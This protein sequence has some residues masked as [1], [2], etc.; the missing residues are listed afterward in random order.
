MAS[1]PSPPDLQSGE[2]YNVFISHG[3]GE[4]DEAKKLLRVLEEEHHL[5]C[6]LPERD[7]LPGESTVRSI[8]EG[9]QMSQKVILLV[10]MTFLK[11]FYMEIEVAEALRKM[12]SQKKTVLIP[13][14][15][16]VDIADVPSSI[17][18]VNCIEMRKEGWMD[19]LL[20]GV[21]AP[22][23]SAATELVPPG[24]IGDGLA[25][26]YYYGY[27]KLILPGLRQRAEESEFAKGGK[28]MLKK[29]IAVLPETA[30]CP[31][32]FEA[33]DPSIKTI[34]AI[35]FLI[36]MSGNVKRSYKTTVHQVT[37]PRDESKVYLFLG[38]FCTPLRSLYEM[39]AGGIAGLTAEDRNHQTLLFRE[40]VKEILGHPNA[41]DCK[42]FLLLPYRDVAVQSSSERYQPQR[43][44]ILLCDAIE[45]ELKIE[46]ELSKLMAE[47]ASV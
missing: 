38:E 21:T 36:D 39:C 26:S 25:W 9:I 11:S 17:K 15:I 43:L 14:L 16:D 13:L 18:A 2:K 7:F 24:N 33:E 23:D 27:L 19:R 31:S 47:S 34:G 8:M 6:L 37:D 10:S 41:T 30:K 20:K 40:K 1:H 28:Q 3:S 45:Y 35:D 46:A 44:S 5:K 42:D 32:T 22:S 4:K 29:F 12:Q